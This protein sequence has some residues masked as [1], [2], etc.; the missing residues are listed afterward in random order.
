MSKLR[1]DHMYLIGILAVAALLRVYQFVKFGPLS[2]DV[3]EYVISKVLDLIIIGLVFGLTIKVTKSRTAGL[4]AAALSVGI[5]LYNWTIAFELY[6]TLALFLYLL[7]IYILMSVK[8][9]EDWWFGLFVPLILSFIHIYSL[10]LVAA[11]ILFV[12]LVKLEKIEF[13]KKELYFIGA[14]TGIIALVF[15]SFT[16]TPALI[17]VI[18]QYINV[19][20]YTLAAENFTLAKALS[21][22]GTLPLYLGILGAYYSVK[23]RS[24][25]SLLLLSTAAIFVLIMLFNIVPISLGLPYFILS[26]AGLSGFVYE[27]FAKT[28]S[29]SRFKSQKNLMIFLVFAVVLIISS[30]HWVLGASV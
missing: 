14:A 7:T 18:K 8:D 10:F 2:I 22:A 19:G 3:D 29:V 24:K 12:I 16:I 17:F 9:M 28:L 5:P 1:K 21:I 15:I 27:K 30:L 4:F 26:L 6:H 11:L 13:S 25:N 23:R 20:Y